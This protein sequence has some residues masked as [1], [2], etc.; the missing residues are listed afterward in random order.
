[1]LH[2]L[3]PSVRIPP[4]LAV[5][6]LGTQI[7][8]SDLTTYSW[9][10]VTAPRDGLIVVMCTA[11]TATGRTFS[12]FNIGGV[13]VVPHFAPASSGRTAAIASREVTAGSIALNTVFSGA[14][15]SASCRI[16]VYFIENYSNPVPYD[17]LAG[18]STTD[19]A[20][21]CNFNHPL[22]GVAIYGALWNDNISG[23]FSSAT[24]TATSSNRAHLHGYIAPTLAQTPH[25]ETANVGASTNGRMTGAVWI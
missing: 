9:T 2:G 18:E 4:P 22:G 11:N 8:T 14:L 3:A 7:S 19:T 16:T 12:T 5:T 10:S 1:M 20:F 25:T 17:G 24:S 15:S 23:S 6:Y 21:P 13:D